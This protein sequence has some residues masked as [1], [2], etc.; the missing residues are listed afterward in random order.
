M[1]VES[2]RH[3]DF[4]ARLQQVLDAAGGGKVLISVKIDGGIHDANIMIRANGVEHLWRVGTGGGQ[5]RID[6]WNLIGAIAE[7]TSKSNFPRDVQR[8]CERT[9]NELRRGW[10][11]L[12]VVAGQTLSARAA[13]QPR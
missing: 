4:K 11:I 3:Y 10:V 12:Q 13:D 6:T 2:V 8:M 5:R 1:T 7:L 9:V